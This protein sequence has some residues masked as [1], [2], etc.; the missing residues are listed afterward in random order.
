MEAVKISDRFSATWRSECEVSNWRLF[1]EIDP[2]G[3]SVDIYEFFGNGTPG[4]VHSGHSFLWSFGLRNKSSVE[5]FIKF[6][7]GDKGQELLCSMCDGW[8]EKYNGSNMVGILTEGAFDAYKAI[9]ADLDS[10][11][12]EIPEVWSPSEWF[13]SASMSDEALVKEICA[14]GSIEDYA[15]EQA[16]ICDGVLCASQIEKYL[17]DVCRRVA[18]NNHIGR[19]LDAKKLLGEDVSG[20]QPFLRLEAL[21]D[22]TEMDEI[23]YVLDDEGENMANALIFEIGSHFFVGYT[24]E[25]DGWKVMDRED[26]KKLN[27]VLEL[28]NGNA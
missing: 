21:Y 4:R 5:D 24:D 12:E 2:E 1:V 17:E 3:R 11:W 25:L 15:S 26:S 28:P 16:T 19:S 9:E 14:S 18:D 6:L 13:D 20:Y 22:K 10:L 23:W 27:L 7:E 8:S